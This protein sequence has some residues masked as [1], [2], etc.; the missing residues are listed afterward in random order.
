VSDPRLWLRPATPADKEALA[1]FNVA[2]HAAAD[3]PA[4]SQYLDRYTRDLFERPH[5]LIAVG[6]H[7][8]I[9]DAETGAIASTVQ[10]IR[11]TWSYGGLPLPV[12]QIELVGTDPAYRRRGL[13][14]R[15]I[16]EAHR[17][18]AERG[19]L[20][21]MIGGK[22]N[23]YRQFGY[24]YALELGG[25][26]RLAP[27]DA[28]A[29]AEGMDEP[30]ALRPAT[31]D[32]APWLAELDRRAAARYRVTCPRDETLWRYEIGGRSANNFFQYQIQIITG[33]DGTPAGALVYTFSR[34]GPRIR[35]I[36][37]ELGAGV[38]WVGVTPTVLRHLDQ[39]GVGHDW[40][41]GVSYQGVVFGLGSAHPLYDAVPGRLWASEA[42][43][44][45][46]MRVADLPA[47]LRQLAPA[48]EQRLVGSA[49]EGYSGTLRLS[50]YRGGALLRFE[51]GRLAET[52]DW[53]PDDANPGDAA[54]PGLTLLPL[55]FGFRSLHELQQAYPD[56]QTCS[57]TAHALLTTL[58]PRQPSR[59][60][61]VV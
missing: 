2:V 9:E 44:A 23:Y 3:N 42:P 17:F 11:Q 13:V 5:P 31:S 15:L 50:W 52:S 38:P 27:G 49:A 28:P 55:L 34:R 46:Y 61:T 4:S 18:S 41:D 21:Q 56:C 47:L 48:L 51:R 19:D 37:A 29:L 33:P 30:F 6:D 20:V 16:A 60:W 14:R 43:Y 54:F 36:A 58:F 32:D 7:L 1:A 53:M 35:V 24:E 26:R 10:L 25:G 59:L 45:A 12:G 39:A 57:D 22:P 8:L 40:G